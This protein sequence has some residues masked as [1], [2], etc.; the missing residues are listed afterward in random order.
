MFPNMFIRNN[1][2]MTR[3]NLVPPSELSRQHLIA[4]YRELP[5][6]FTLARK[7]YRRDD[8]K[9]IPEKYTMGQGHVRF[10]YNKL[11]FLGRRYSDLVQEMRD[12]GYKPNPILVDD[13]Y[14]GIP[15]SL[16]M[17]YTPTSE[18]LEINRQRIFERNKS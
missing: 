17:W 11:G 3:I 8:I 2:K 13:L 16:I 14:N 9:N 18:A 4:E 7:A 15:D 6:A 12:R 1:K 5:R 10:F